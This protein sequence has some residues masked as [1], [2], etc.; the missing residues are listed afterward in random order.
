MRLVLR[1][2]GLDDDVHGFRTTS[3][4]WAPTTCSTR[5]ISP[6]SNSRRLATARMS[7]NVANEKTVSPG[8]AVSGAATQGRADCAR[9]R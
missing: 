8:L 5:S 3:K 6:L 4:S 9:A 2:L 1:E 7:G